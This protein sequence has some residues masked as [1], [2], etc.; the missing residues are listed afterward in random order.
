M[1]TDETKLNPAV[2]AIFKDEQEKANKMNAVEVKQ[3]P[4]ECGA[5]GRFC[6]TLCMN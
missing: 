2:K 6:F 4:F 3:K 5:K 1:K